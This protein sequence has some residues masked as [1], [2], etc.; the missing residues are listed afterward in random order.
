MRNMWRVAAFDV[1]APLAMLA[2]LAYVGFVLAWPLWWAAVAAVL[3]LLVVQCSVINVVLFRRDGVTLGTDDDR[4]VLRLVIAALATAAVVGAAVVGYLTWTVEDRELNADMGTVVGI[5]SHVAEASA[6]FTP[7]APNASIDEAASLMAPQ[8]AEAY[9]REF[10]D[11]AKDL[12][13]RGVSGQAATISAGVEGISPDLASVAVLLRGTQNAP[14][15]PQKVAILALRVTL[16]K[17]H[18]RWLVA[19]VTPINAR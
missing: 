11:V 2:G 1:L 4:P 14:G 5:A 9:R 18:D 16:V 17:D 3:A 12:T 8:R 19:D 15:Q 13:S 6:T 7:G 10:N